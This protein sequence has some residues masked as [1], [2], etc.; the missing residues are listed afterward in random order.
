MFYFSA[1]GLPKHSFYE[2][3]FIFLCGL[4]QL[5]WAT[6]RCMSLNHFFESSGIHWQMLSLNEDIKSKRWRFPGCISFYTQRIEKINTVV[7][8][9]IAML[10]FSLGFIFVGS[11]SDSFCLY[12]YFLD[13]LPKRTSWKLPGMICDLSLKHDTVLLYFFIVYINMNK[14]K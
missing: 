11:A 3:C 9:F 13:L 7:V 14:I 4:L 10:L 5:N 2:V 12:T 8:C 1:R 6:K